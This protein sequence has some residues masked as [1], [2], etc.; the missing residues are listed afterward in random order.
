MATK[1]NDTVFLVVAFIAV[2]N[3]IAYLNVRDWNSLAVFA[4]IAGLAYA[5]KT[6]PTLTLV[7]AIIAAS[8]FRASNNMRREGYKNKEK[9]V[10]EKKKPAKKSSAI[11]IFGDTT[12]GLM[13]VNRVQQN[14][15][16]N[17]AQLSPMLDQM[18]AVMK[19][20]PEGFIENAM[21]NFQNKMRS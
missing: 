1:S 14:L 6:G 3:I 7:V 17:M 19:N 11:D 16:A 8:L 12:E 15:T 13:N 4:L 10:I 2:L 5:F 20:M 18:N 9:K 21:K